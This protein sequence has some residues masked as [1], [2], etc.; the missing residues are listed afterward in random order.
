VALDP[1]AAPLCFFEGDLLTPAKIF[2]S[3]RESQ[4]RVLLPRRGFPPLPDSSPR[5]SLRLSRRFS[6][7]FFPGRILLGVVDS[8]RTAL[9]VHFWLTRLSFPSWSTIFVRRGRLFRSVDS[10]IGRRYRISPRTRMTVCLQTPAVL[11]GFPNRS[12]LSNAGR[13]SSY[14]P[15]GGAAPFVAEALPVRLLEAYRVF[16]GRDPRPPCPAVR[17]CG[18][19]SGFFRKSAVADLSF[20]FFLFFPFFF[21][22]TCFF[23]SQK[24]R[25]CLFL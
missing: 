19:L 9:G 1:I 22:N 23:R 10:L 8:I 5:S 14:F 2:P 24:H 21:G 16:A 6:L 12:D 3:L 20:D 18:L 15:S 4:G 13:P 25:F 17:H 7:V 11:A